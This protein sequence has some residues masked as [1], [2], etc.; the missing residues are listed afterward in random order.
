MGM[1]KK[2]VDIAVR[3]RRTTDKAVLVDMGDDEEFWLP[4][5]QC[6][7]PSNPDDHVGQTVE[8]KVAEWLATGKGLV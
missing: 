1:S 3:I 5:S 4:K 6:E 2:M 7:F 8:V